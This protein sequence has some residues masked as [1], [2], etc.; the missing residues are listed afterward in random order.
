M[1][2]EITADEITPE[3]RVMG[4]NLINRLRVMAGLDWDELALFLE[5]DPATLELVKKNLIEALR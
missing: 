3:Q 5:G 2:D 4:A 1:A